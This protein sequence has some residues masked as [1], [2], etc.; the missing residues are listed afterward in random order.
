MVRVMHTHHRSQDNEVMDK[1]VEP[2]WFRSASGDDR[3]IAARH[4]PD[5]VGR[6]SV[7]A[8][9]GG[10]ARSKDMGSDEMSGSRSCRFGAV[11]GEGTG[12][13]ALTLRASHLKVAPSTIE[14]C[15]ASPRPGRQQCPHRPRCPDAMARDRTGARSMARHPEQGWSL[16]CNGVVI[17]DDG[18]SLLPDGRTVPPAPPRPRTV[19]PAASASGPRCG[20]DD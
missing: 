19:A 9:Y 3:Q 12:S 1:A 6:R 4:V 16:L 5:P 11:T 20:Q 18:G 15:R 14:P 7:M 13:T 10:A 8:G 2:R 17:F